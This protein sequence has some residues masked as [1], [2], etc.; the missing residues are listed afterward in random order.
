MH[1]R[2]AHTHTQAHA[3][4]HSCMHRSKTQNTLFKSSL[5]PK[6]RKGTLRAILRSLHKTDDGILETKRMEPEPELRVAYCYLCPCQLSFFPYFC[7]FFRKFHRM[8]VGKVLLFARSLCL[9]VPLKCTDEVNE[10]S[11]WN[12]FPSFS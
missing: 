1:S 3:H 10:N 12:T 8:E 6:Q 9:K 11:S 5:R 2:D 7:V 4:T